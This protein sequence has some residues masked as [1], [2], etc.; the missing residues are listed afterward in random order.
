[1][2]SPQKAPR[3]LATLCASPSVC[4]DF[5]GPQCTPTRMKL[6]GV[7]A[8]ASM[9]AIVGKERELHCWA[10]GD[11]WQSA[12]ANRSCVDMR[13]RNVQHVKQLAVGASSGLA[14]TDE[15][16]VYFWGNAHAGAIADIGYEAHAPEIISLEHAG[17][18]GNTGA[19]FEDQAPEVQI[20][21]SRPVDFS[22]R[23]ALAPKQLP[24]VPGV[25]GVI[26]SGHYNCLELDSKGAYCEYVLG[27]VPFRLVA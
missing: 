23:F 7:R 27:R 21:P 4:A 26:A 17:Q 8:I 20:E 5:H 15:G 10:G 3:W 1:M 14:L 12:D 22:A 13:L 9:C 6:S 18:R 11:G 19:S 16:D 24:S 25:R 2:G